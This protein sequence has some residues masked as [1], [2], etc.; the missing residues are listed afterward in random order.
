[1]TSRQV[2][3]IEAPAKINLG[4]EI[5]G[6]RPDGFHE[7]RTVMVMLELADTLRVYSGGPPSG[8]ELPDVPAETNLVT[9]ALTAF[10][11]AV[12]GSPELGWSIEKRIPVAA[13]LGGASSNAAAALLAANELAGHALPREAM[14]DLAGSLGTDITFFLGGPAALA[15]GRGTELESLSPV[16]QP[17]TLLLPGSSI[18]AKTR[19]LYSM[20]NPVDMTDGLRSG[21]SRR[22]VDDHSI[23]AMSDLTNAFSRP[24]SILVPGVLELQR[25]LADS[26]VDRF[27]LSGAGPTHYVI[28]GDA[29]DALSA[30]A[31][32]DRRFDMFEIISTRT[33]LTPLIPHS[34][35]ERS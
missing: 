10:R 27:G 1:M 18:P 17:V 26:G 25:A 22:A 30:R 4:L 33:R 5:L 7:I 9:A 3:T 13:G 24:L 2:V 12:P 35:T 34:S 28:G 15:S 16:D 6:K 14:F 11:Q 8:T 23:P 32:E 21:R 29:C 31:P 19:T 20:I